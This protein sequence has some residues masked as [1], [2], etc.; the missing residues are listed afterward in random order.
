MPDSRWQLLE[1]LLDEAAAFP[2]AERAAYL[3]AACPDDEIRAEVESLLAAE[4]EADGYFADLGGALHGDALAEGGAMQAALTETLVGTQIGRWHIDA[5]LGQ[6]GMGTVYRVTRA[7]GVVEQTA[8]LKLLDSVR[9]DVVARFAQERQILARLDHPG[10]ARLLDGG[11]TPEGRPYLVM[12]YVDGVPITAYATAQRLSVEARVALVAEVCEAVQAAH[13][14][15]VVHR[16]LKPSNIF[17]QTTGPRAEPSDEQTQTRSSVS[18]VKLLD[19]GI[20]KLL[21][22]DD[23]ALRTQTEQRLL[24]PAYAAPEQLDG[25][26]ISTATDVY[27]LGVVLYELLTGQRPFEAATPSALAA[28]QLQGDAR[29]PSTVTATGSDARLAEVGL[30]GVQPLRRALR[31]D[32]DAICLKALRRDPNARYSSVEALHDDLLRTLDGRPVAAREGATAYRVGRFVRRHALAVSLAV[33][34]VLALVG[35]LGVA[36]WQA[37]VA[38]SEAE[39]AREQARRA[40][41]TVAFMTGLFESVGP[42]EARGRALAPADL[43]ARGRAQID[44]LDTQ[45]GVQGELLAVMGRLYQSLGLYAAADSLHTEALTLR[46]RLLGPEHPDVAESLFDRGAALFILRDFSAAD[47]LHRRAYSLRAA[48]LPPDDP[49]LLESIVALAASASN[50]YDHVRADSLFSVA[51]ERWDGP[52]W[53]RHPARLSALVGRATLL[54]D[55]QRPA[56]AEQLFRTALPLLTETRGTDHPDVADVHY[57]L[58]EA[59]AAQNRDAEALDAHRRALDLYRHLHGDAHDLVATSLYRLA[60]IEE[61]TGSLAQ[62]EAH[63]REAAVVYAETLGRDHVWSAYPLIALARLLQGAG[64]PSDALAAL[65]DARTIYLAADLD[66]PDGRMATLDLQA[67]RVLHELGRHREAHDRLTASQRSYQAQLTDALTDADTAAVAQAQDRLAAI[68]TT[69][70]ALPE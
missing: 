16:D 20:A 33:V 23:A 52:T 18:R 8:A 3:D 41:A 69:L 42:E 12:E 5:P 1:Q 48:T 44:A 6:G 30:P 67:G 7:D 22:D 39:I 13:Q 60:R 65:D 68:E 14:R 31:G 62:A 10:L 43:V 17:V 27:A 64:R 53:E 35:G 2:S 37:R 46:Q 50:F 55:E 59:L 36:L 70:A 34:A 11:A 57:N 32:L 58:G 15:L 19:F 49:R 21:A 24:T 61:R 4:E 45:P 28:A 51:L 47:S 38:A 66:H 54:L 29:R 25:G 40:E 56:D 63:Y 9:P 26:A